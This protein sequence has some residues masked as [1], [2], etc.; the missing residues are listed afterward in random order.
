[1][2]SLID[3]YIVSTKNWQCR[4]EVESTTQKLTKSE[5]SLIKFV[6]RELSI[7]RG[8]LYKITK[9]DGVGYKIV[10]QRRLPLEEEF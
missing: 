6:G 4:I 8:W 2:N 9:D 10:E 5:P 7:L 1:M 3:T